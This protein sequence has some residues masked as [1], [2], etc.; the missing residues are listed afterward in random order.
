MVETCSLPGQI[1]LILTWWID[2]LDESEEPFGDLS[3][4]AGNFELIPP[5]LMGNTEDFTSGDWWILYDAIGSY[6]HRTPTLDEIYEI[7]QMGNAGTLP[8]GKTKVF[9]NDDDIEP[10]ETNGHH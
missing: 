3:E 4:I 6:P 10:P 9:L 8:K 7:C 1:A 5:L 2:G